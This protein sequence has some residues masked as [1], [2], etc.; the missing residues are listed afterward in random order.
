M[1]KLFPVLLSFLISAP[2]AHGDNA[3]PTARKLR[4]GVI[5]P[6]TGG[7]EEVTDDFVFSYDGLRCFWPRPP[8]AESR[9]YRSKPA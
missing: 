8:L 6:L 7:E 4:V 3:L 2:T 1:K 5:A 9:H